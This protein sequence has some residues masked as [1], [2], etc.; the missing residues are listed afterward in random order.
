ML[1]SHFII[2]LLCVQALK[3]HL[4]HNS[5][6]SWQL[7]EKFLERKISEQVRKA[8]ARNAF[9]TTANSCYLFN[10][11]LCFSCMHNR[12]CT[13]ERN[14]VLSPS[15]RPTGDQTKDSE[16]RCWMQSTSYQWTLMVRPCRTTAAIYTYISGNAHCYATFPWRLNALM[17]LPG[18]SDPFVQLSLEP[19]HIFPEVEL[20]CTQIKSCDLNPLFDEAFEL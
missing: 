1:H 2:S 19:N 14:M 15:S 5:L 18:F 3:A 17:L 10:L 4:T 7:M 12:M 8:P 11:S 16:L 9:Q 13:A 6:S 20:R